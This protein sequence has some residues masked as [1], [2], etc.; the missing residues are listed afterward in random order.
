MRSIDATLQSTLATGHFIPSFKLKVYTNTVLTSTL[1]VIKY[2]LTGTHLSVTVRGLLPVSNSPEWIKVIL[3]RGAVVNGTPIM[4]DTSL[5]T[6]V[7]GSIEKVSSR[8]LYVQSSVECE[9]IPPRILTT[10]NAS[11]SYKS[12]I[13]AFC[14]QIGKT[15]VYKDSGAAFWTSEFLGQGTGLTLNNAQLFLPLLIQKHLIIAC[16]AGSEN[17]LFYCALDMPGAADATI[18]LLMLNIGTGYYGQRNFLGTD[19]YGVQR[20][21]GNAADP[22]WNLGYV[23]DIDPMPNYYVQNTPI[24]FETLIN[25]NYQD[26]DRFTV[27]AGNYSLYPAQVTE[28]FD[29]KHNPGWCLAIQQLI[30]FTNTEGG[31]LPRD[32]VKSAGMLPL[33]TSLFNGV[34][35]A[36]ASTVQ[37]AMDLLDD[38]QHAG[39]TAIPS[40]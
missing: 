31:Q 36:S 7:T 33:N 13:D 23:Q 30:Y 22:L 4:L 38:H 16:D 19:Q 37:A 2:K 6:P 29:R 25:L 20:F 27:D 5:F 40:I 3:S 34:L 39:G 8:G 18:D 11:G 10:I 21:A 28:I 9:L 15:A 12:V 35:N 24:D 1:D 26:G 14:T 32:I 17:I